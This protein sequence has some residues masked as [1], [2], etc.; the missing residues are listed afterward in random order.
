MLNLYSVKMALFLL[1]GITS[2]GYSLYNTLSIVQEVQDK[3]HKIYWQIVLNFIIFFLIT[4]ITML[5]LSSTIDNSNMVMRIVSWI[6]LFG[7]F[8]IVGITY[9]DKKSI[10]LLEE[11]VKQCTTELREKKSKIEKLHREQQSLLLT[12]PDYLF[13]LHRSGECEQLYMPED[14]QTITSLKGKNIYLVNP[15]TPQEHL[16]NTAQVIIHTHFINNTL[17][18]SKDNV[19][20]INFEL[21]I[22]KEKKYFETRCIKLSHYRVFALVRNTTKTKELEKSLVKQKNQALRR[23]SME[24]NFL[25]NMSHEIRTPMNAILGLT[26]LLLTTKLTHKQKKYL[27]SVH[28]SGDHLLHLI[29][30]ILDLSKIR[31]GKMSLEIITFDIKKMLHDTID[32]MHVLINNKKIILKLNMKNNIPQYVGGDPYQI[33]QIITNLVNNAIKFTEKGY[34]QIVIEQKQK[35]INTKS[36]NHADFTFSIIDTGI[37]IPPESHKK[38]F[39]QFTQST[40]STSRLFGG[41]GLGLS[42]TKKLIHSMHGVIKLESPVHTEKTKYGPG[43]KISFTIPLQKLTGKSIDEYIDLE[44]HINAVQTHDAPASSNVQHEYRNTKQISAQNDISVLVAEDNE[45]NQLLIRKM[46]EKLPYQMIIASDGMEAVSMAKK[47][48]PDII[49]MDISMPKLNGYEATKKLRNS[50][51]TTPIIALTAHVMTQELQKVKQSGMNDYLLKP[52]NTDEL[53]QVI[54]QFVA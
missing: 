34:I 5:V 27:N 25:A 13:T 38:I 28:V 3:K 35:S 9:I 32:S 42:I 31:A 51:Y 39:E 46:L 23:A 18:F 40:E 12:L 1:I 6:F 45:V 50:N 15:N 30:D 54:K 21:D 8:F 11:I 14:N 20:S 41:T 53:V 47:Y 33:K 48:K 44:K 2:M 49:F 26:D 17:N 52:F 4:Y 36:T 22:N 7:V 19:F 43:T 37:G 10:I 29:N 16:V 24:S